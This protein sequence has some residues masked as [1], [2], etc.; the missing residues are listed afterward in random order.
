VQDSVAHPNPRP[1]KRS[2]L[3]PAL[4]SLCFQYYVVEAFSAHKFP[5]Y[6]FHTN[7]ISDL[8]AIH[9]AA[10][11]CSPRH[12]FMNASFCV[13]GLLILVGAL[14]IRPL[15]R[16]NFS[17]LAGFI[18]LPISGL[19]LIGVGLWP[20]DTNPGMHYAAAAAHFMGSGFGMLLLG[21]SLLARQRT[22]WVGLFTF[23]SGFITLA[24]T[25]LVWQKIGLGM[26]LGGMERVAA[27]PFTVW[28][29]GMGIGML[30]ARRKASS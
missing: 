8:G 3:G 5:A 16:Q 2:L 26:G 11:M 1:R 30:T 17:T 24:A 9:C 20:E 25:V 27:Y 4:W 15:F 29:V 13:Q 12:A 28:L 19:G 22:R 7:F 18:L 10:E 23:T 14:L 6:S 21:R